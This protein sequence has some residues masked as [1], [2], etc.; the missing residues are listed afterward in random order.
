MA[1]LC[2]TQS[3]LR[4]SKSN[5]NNG[6]YGTVSELGNPLLCGPGPRRGPQPGF[7]IFTGVGN[8]G[9]ARLGEGIKL[10]FTWAGYLRAARRPTT[11]Q[12][13]RKS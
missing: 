7:S 13:C 4:K 11:I 10:V 1:E 3:F 12:L 9:W 6:S 2:H 8:C 5:D